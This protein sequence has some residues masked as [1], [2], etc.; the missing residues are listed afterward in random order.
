MLFSKN[1]KYISSMNTKGIFSNTYDEKY[2]QTIVNKLVLSHFKNSDKTPK[3]IFIGWD[4][5]RGDAMKYLI[6]SEN[7][8]ISGANDD[9]N[10]SAV[11]LLKKTGGVYI[12]YVGGDNGFQQETSTAQGWASALCGKWMKKE[13]KNGIEWSLDADYE[14]VMQTL[15]KQGFKTSF[16]CIWPVH[17]ENTYKNEIEYAQK[18]NLSESYF[19]FETDSELHEN[20]LSRINS[21]DDFIFGIYENP[22]LNGHGTGF[23]DCNYRYVSGICN[24][25]TFS[26]DLIKAVEKRDT[27]KNE[28]WL[29]IIG[30]DHGGHLNMHG[31]Q[32]IEDRTTFLAVS[33]SVKELID[34]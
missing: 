25:D 31:T 26:Y 2:P 32:R 14:T 15:A 16:N 7:E 13:W 24:L 3:C 22:D 28:D 21:D 19:K 1:K 4:G 12:T 8:K 10:Y 33:K 34:R 30:S 9:F 5:C 6:K 17:F 18:N 20:M 11:N 29:I 27:F 23:G